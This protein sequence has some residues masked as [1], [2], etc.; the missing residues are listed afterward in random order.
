MSL[1]L[2]YM[3]SCF[4]FHF[5]LLLLGNVQRLQTVRRL[6]R[7]ELLRV[8]SPGAPALVSSSFNRHFRHLN[9]DL[10]FD[11]N[12]CLKYEVSLPLLL[13]LSPIS[14]AADPLPSDLTVSVTPP[15]ASVSQISCETQQS[16]RFTVSTPGF[17]TF[18]CPFCF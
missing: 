12:S 18:F 1:L 2:H 4:F 17:V 7:N 13:S 16:S 9:V 6:L 14:D 3:S 5:L 15:F 11:K 10:P 8:C